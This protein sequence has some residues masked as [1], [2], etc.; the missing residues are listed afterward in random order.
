[1]RRI[2]QRVESDG[3]V[4]GVR[5][6]PTMPLDGE[7]HALPTNWPSR[8][9]HDT[10][11]DWFPSVQWLKTFN[12]SLPCLPLPLILE[13]QMKGFRKGLSAW[14]I[15]TNN[16]CWMS[17][18]HVSTFIKQR[19][20]KLMMEQYVVTQAL[21]GCQEHF[22]QYLTAVHLCEVVGRVTYI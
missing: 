9:R 7:W 16:S 14:G 8:R 4:G 12:A 20:R 3:Q 13:G 10:A 22:L 18:G 15:I 1:M 17:E 5:V 2:R 11:G 21:Q 19:P 6:Q